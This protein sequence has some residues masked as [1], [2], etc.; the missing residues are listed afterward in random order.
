[1]RTECT[2]S[3]ASKILYHSL[4]PSLP[5]DI[6]GSLN[7]PGGNPKA[8]GAPPLPGT[9]AQSRLNLGAQSSASWLPHLE[10][11]ALHPDA[12][13]LSTCDP[14]KQSLPKQP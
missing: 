13:L 9:E 7:F 2:V 5:Q 6:H 3:F 4:R 10:L 1:M 11:P 14:Q 12:F 8:A